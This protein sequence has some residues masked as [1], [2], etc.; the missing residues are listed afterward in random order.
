MVI[1]GRLV[2]NIGIKLKGTSKK[3]RNHFII[4]EIKNKVSTPL[5]IKHRHLGHV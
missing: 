4:V 5:H 2:N 3:H 1:G